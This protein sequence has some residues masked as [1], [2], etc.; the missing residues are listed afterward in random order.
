MSGVGCSEG[1]VLRGFLRMFSAVLANSPNLERQ[2]HERPATA[3]WRDRRL[4]RAER[5]GAAA[6]WGEDMNVR[7]LRGGSAHRKNESRKHT[8]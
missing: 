5:L 6:L 8:R 1:R 2:S 3:A 4:V 7:Q